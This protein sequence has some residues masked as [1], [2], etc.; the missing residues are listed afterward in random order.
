VLAAAGAVTTMGAAP[1]STPVA[2]SPD[3]KDRRLNRLA[4]DRDSRAIGSSSIDCWSGASSSFG[5]GVD[6]DHGNLERRS[7]LSA[8]KNLLGNPSPFEYPSRSARCVERS[9]FRLLEAIADTLEPMSIAAII[10]AAGA[11]RRLGQPKQLLMHGGQTLLGRAIRL[12]SES[13]AGPVYAVLGAHSERINASIKSSVATI[14]VNNDWEQGIASSIYAGLRTLDTQALGVLI[15]SCDQP[16]LTAEHLRTLIEVFIAQPAPAIV[17]SVYAGA[18]G[19]PAVF[20]RAL[21]GD[22]LALKGDRGAHAL[23]HHP[24]CPLIAVPFP[25][26]EADIDEPGDLVLLE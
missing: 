17:A 10:L 7:E 19:V 15:L 12:A 18:H 22:L 11:S 23:M 6:R 24:P 3:R 5:C 4:L 8:T 9:C 13:G 16:R 26:G 14:V 1:A 25:G 21:F 2:P 20:P